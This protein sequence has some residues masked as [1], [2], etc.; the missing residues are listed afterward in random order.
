MHLLPRYG[1][2][3]RFIERD[4]FKID[5]IVPM[6]AAAQSAR[7]SP[8][9]AISRGVAGL[10]R[11]FRRLVP[12]IVVVLGDRFEPLAAAMAAVAEGFPLA[13]LHG[14]DRSYA[15][16]VDETIRHAITKLAHLHFPATRRSARRIAALGEEKWRIHMVGSTALDELKGEGLLSR[17]QICREFRLDSTL[18]FLLVV[19]HPVLLE[20]RQAGAQMKETMFAIRQAR[21]QAVVIYP[22][23]D[24]GSDK[25]IDAILSLGVCP[26]IKIHKSV[27]REK[28]VALMRHAAAMVGNS[29][30][31]LIEAPALGLPM[32]HVGNRNIGREHANNVT[33]VPHDRNIIRREIEKL[34]EVEKTR[35]R[36]AKDSYE[37]APRK[38][39]RSPYGNGTA[40]ERIVGVLENLPPR[41]KLLSKQLTYA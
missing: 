24:P 2:T 4:N 34:L 33:F 31:G 22:N 25:I 7:E 40:A 9:E 11:A 13:H 28:Y 1:R 20:H 6:Y 15:G 19:Q 36:A 18:P 26:F 21:A 17:T 29:S 30:S 27:S 16:H 5:E 3:V 37:P 12:D 35:L 38:A 23:N 10:A 41:E 32:V 39:Y 14:G 8:G